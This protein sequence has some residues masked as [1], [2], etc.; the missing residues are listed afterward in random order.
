MGAPVMVSRTSPT[1]LSVELATAWNMTVIGYARRQG[2]RVYAAAERVVE[3]G[4]LMI[5]D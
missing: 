2:F 3:G 1:S 5:K 4:G